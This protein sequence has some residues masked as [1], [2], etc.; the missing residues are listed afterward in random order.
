MRVRS[1]I[2]HLFPLTP[3]PSASFR[4]TVRSGRSWSAWTTRAGGRS[5]S[6]RRWS[7]CQGWWEMELAESSRRPRLTTAMAWRLT[8]RGRRMAPGMCRPHRGVA[9]PLR[10]W[11]AVA[12]GTGYNS[13]PPATGGA[14]ASAGLRASEICRTATMVLVWWGVARHPRP[15]SCREQLSSSGAAF[16]PLVLYRAEGEILSCRPSLRGR[17]LIPH[18]STL[19]RRVTLF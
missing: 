15:R 9:S 5:L 1:F 13:R 14:R 6:P 8:T 2:V 10:L 16:L 19:P 12:D 4:Q 11:G 3:T 18:C 7:E 17:S